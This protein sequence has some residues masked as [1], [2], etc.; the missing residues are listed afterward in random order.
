MEG[1]RE[2]EMEVEVSLRWCGDEWKIFCASKCSLLCVGNMRAIFVG[3]SLNIFSFW[4]V[5]VDILSA[6]L[7]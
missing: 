7:Y 4:C 5:D 3:Y 1:K 2:E 6:K